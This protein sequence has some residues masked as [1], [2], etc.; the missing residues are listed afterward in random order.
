VPD[1]G[2]DGGHDQRERHAEDCPFADEGP[3]RGI[4]QTR[5]DCGRRPKEDDVVDRAED[6]ERD[7]RRQE[8][9]KPEIADQ[10]A[11]DRAADDAQR[12]HREEAKPDRPTFDIHANEREQNR[13]RVDGGHRKVD[14]AGDHHDRQSEHDQPE[15][16]ELP[17]EI[18]EPVDREEARDQRAENA[19]CNNKN[20]EG[21][22]VVDPALGQ[23]F[24]DQVIGEI[25][26]TQ[27]GE[28]IPGAARHGRGSVRV[29]RNAQQ[30]L[31]RVARDAQHPLT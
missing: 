7:Q 1:D 24:P 11:I 19:D 4:R 3:N 31:V 2:N 18:A 28:D 14:A 6:D 29:A 26:I 9:A 13:E 22:R 17:P 10:I 20:D 8:G 30:P 21:D 15:L 16:G 27:L 25:L 12:H 5:N 23:Y